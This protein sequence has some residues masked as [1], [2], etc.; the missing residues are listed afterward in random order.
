M[1]KLSKMT[2]KFHDLDY[3]ADADMYI[4]A[5]RN[6]IPSIKNLRQAEE[7]LA[8][9]I[10]RTKVESVTDSVVLAYHAVHG[11]F[12]SNDIDILNFVETAA[13]HSFGENL[14]HPIKAVRY[15]ADKGMLNFGPAQTQEGIDY[16]TANPMDK[17]T[18]EYWQEVM[19]AA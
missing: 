17:D 16:Y 8:D 4:A 14:H 1:A 11:E 10:N 2:V 9:E 13:D 18:L 6:S 12:P 3:S 5:Y 7:F 15:L 19:A